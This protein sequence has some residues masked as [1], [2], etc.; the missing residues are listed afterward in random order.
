MIDAPVEKV[1]GLIL[2]F[3]GMPKWHP[4]VRDSHIANGMPSDAIG[5]ARNF[6]L[7]NGDHLREQLLTVSDRDRECVYCILN[8][9]PPSPATS[10][11]IA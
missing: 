2:D 3:N 1:W 9:P 10:P 5:C 6:H 4:F 7:A 11:A 8:S